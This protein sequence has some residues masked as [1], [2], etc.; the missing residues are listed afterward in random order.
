MKILV[1]SPVYSLAGVPLAQFR[2]AKSLGEIGHDVDLI[3]G[4]KKYKKIEKTKN[5]EI[6][7]L[8]K[9]RVIGMLLPL[10]KYLI[11]NKPKIIFSAEDHLNVIVILAKILSFSKAKISTSSR[12]TP[13]DTYY[14]SDRLFSKGWFLKKFYPLVHWKADAM[15]CVAKDMVKQYKKIFKYTKQVGVYN[16]IQDKDS[17]I[18]MKEK[19]DHSW[20]KNNK[21]QLIVAS[22][23]LA[24]W[25][26]FDV[27]IDAAKI[28]DKRK[29]NF[30]IAII[31]GG[32]EK[33][34][35]NK[36]I[37][38]NK[39]E[40]KI[41]IINPVT[42]TL[43]Y[44]YNSD[45]FVLSSR[46]EGMPNVMIEAMM[47]GCTVVA[48][49]CPTGPKEIIGKN[50]YGYLSKINDPQDL[51]KNILKAINKKIPQKKTKKILAKFS[52]NQVIKKHFS[53]LKIK[54]EYW[55]ID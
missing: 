22:G 35:L 34:F 9:F 40:N 1:V 23:K 12:V 55:K 6:I 49:D 31:G 8:N 21:T 51:S 41:R 52:A 4:C 43:K 24:K 39:L 45:I 33:K 15:T 54:R 32:P 2:L 53:L 44:F 36:L 18:K 30:K 50:I 38:L 19:L 25:K 27:L 3:Y 16:I 13:I 20:F 10:V 14:D 17:I 48:T 37:K 29:I 5:I 42:N 46:V 47:C 28:L 11:L 26:G 7:F